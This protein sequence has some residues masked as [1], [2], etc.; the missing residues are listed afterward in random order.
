MLPQLP[1]LDEAY[2]DESLLGFALRMAAR[3]GLK[4]LAG[5]AQVLGCKSVRDAGSTLA[6]VLARLFGASPTRLE[7]LA[8]QS[9]WTG[10]GRV[11]TFM[12]QLL[13]KPWMLRAHR[14]QVC[15]LCLSD[16]GYVRADWD[17]Q[18]LTRC[19]THGNRL[20]DLCPNCRD[21]LS[22]AR[23]TIMH[24]GC[25]CRLTT[26]SRAHEEPCA[27]AT[28]LA[29]LVGL[30]LDVPVVKGTPACRS[31]TPLLEALSLDGAMRVVWAFGIRRDSDDRVTTGVVRIPFRTHQLEALVAR[32]VDRLEQL[33]HRRAGPGAPAVH[34]STLATMAREGQTSMDRSTA[35]QLLLLMG[36]KRW[37]SVHMHDFHPQS[38]LTLF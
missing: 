11:V 23:P 18:M 17:L 27:A 26:V 34:M 15:P 6:P 21:P 5:I 25:G 13:S 1:S 12:G 2:P 31:A 29:A 24:C 36:E 22:W 9:R 19:R 30:R 28:T 33:A 32:A 38:Q 35:A 8:Q 20:V 37:Q 7:F 16:S 14:P 3:N 4:G 10:D